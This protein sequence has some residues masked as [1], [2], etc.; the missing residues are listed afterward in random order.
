MSFSNK[1]T[2]LPDMGS[3]PA[4]LYLKVKQIIIHQVQSGVWPPHFRIPSEA[5]LVEQLSVSRM[6]V[7]RALRELT[8]E[9]ILVRMQGVGS[10][11]AEPKGQTALFE[12][13]NIAD[14]ITERGHRH[15]SQVI[16]IEKVLADTQQ[17]SAF[18]VNE[19]FPLFHS[20]LV[21]Y[22]NGIA[23]QIEDRYINAQIVP[24]YLKQDFTR[25]TPNQYL[26]EMV[27]ATEGEHVVEAVLPTREESDLL[28][29]KPD[30]PCLLMYRRTWSGNAVISSA[31]LLYPGSRYRLKGRFGI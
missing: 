26:N 19:N 8:A 30:E 20:I 3:S 10:F 18:E 31:R 24:N 4:P 11:V 1:L 6:T 25:V 16:V 21:H 14:E 29:I 7:N 2:A 27:P 28:K 12:I 13:R 23:V 9:G 15:L 22:E 5:E 17:A